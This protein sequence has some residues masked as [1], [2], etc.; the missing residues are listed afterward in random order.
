MRRLVAFLGLLVIA[1]CRGKE[2]TP[3]VPVG[4]VTLSRD[5]ATLIPA[6]TVQLTASVKDINGNPLSR[7]VTW[8]TSNAARATVSTA[9]LVQGVAT[10]V[11]SITATVDNVTAATQVAVKEGAIVGAS[12]GTVTALGGAATLIIPAGALTSNVMITIERAIN[13]PTTARLVGGSAVDLEPAGLQ[14]AS[15][16][17]LRLKYSP[18]QLPTGASEQLLRMQQAVGTAWQLVD[19]SSVDTAAKIV[20]ADLTGLSIYAVLSSPISSVSLATDRATLEIGE[21]VQLVATALDDANAPVTDAPITW[22]SA[23]PAI[24]SVSSTGLVTA[25][26]PGGPVD[27]SATS[28]GRSAKASITVTAK[29]FVGVSTTAINFAAAANGP[30]PASQQVAVSSIDIATL[31]GL[32]TSIAYQTGQPTGWLTATL[33]ATTTPTQLTLQ[34]TTATLGAGTYVA[35]VTVASS[36]PATAS[37]TI[38]VSFTVSSP[39]IAVNAGNSQAAMAGVP[40]PVPPS[41]VV[42]DGNGLPMPNATVTFLPT[43]G[44]G[45]VAGATATTDA[46]GVATV[47]SWTLSTIGNPDSLIATVSG[48]GFSSANNSIMFGAVGCTGGG[49][50]G[51]AI[52]IC[53]ATRMSPA[54]RSA[55]LD[56]AARWGSLITGDIADV[57]VSIP[58]GT[59]SVN[60]PSVNMTID[61]LLIFARIEPIDGVNGVLGSAGPCVIRNSN[62]LPIIGLMRFDDAD[63]AGLLARGQLNEVI[64]HEMGHVIG[65]GTLWQNFHLLVN[66]STPGGQTLDT[67]YIG[68]G[69][70]A[71]FDLIGGITYTGSLKV[72][73]ENQGGAGTINGHWRESVLANELMTGFLNSGSNPL[74][75][76]TVRSLEDLGYTVNAAGA[77][78]FQLTLSLQAQTQAD[79][80]RRPYGDDVIHGPMYSIDRNGRLTRIRF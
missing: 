46:N 71:G 12:G 77:D 70:L 37:A 66:P 7:T 80:N 1:A 57:T 76:L 52:T 60:S 36:V 19:G 22:I 51:Y 5:T 50:T 65:I 58:A 47:G 75:V 31:N 48:P 34:A 43:D 41:V 59:C 11:V 45:T 63:V 53:F 27:V 44:S 33:T 14:F 64:L 39:S 38:N 2:A 21:T 67:H 79:P 28:N 9:G 73:V 30:D 24:A 72:P 29:Q 3:P 18:G 25:V 49:G 32:T 10:G 35:T 55:F 4:S 26:A 54:Q 16:A 42:R 6:A 40:V 69:G 23:N 68:A 74:S 13:T 61:D 17:Q 20:N 56:A 62:Q 15:V 78:P 8:A